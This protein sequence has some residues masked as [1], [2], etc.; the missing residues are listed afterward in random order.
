MKKTTV[1][2]F[3]A[4][5]LTL[6]AGGAPRAQVTL[7]QD[8]DAGALDVAASVVDL[9]NPLQPAITLE[10]RRFSGAW[11]GDHW[12]VSFSVS[13]VAGTT[14]RFRLPTAGAFQTYTNEHRWVW[15]AT[16]S[17]ETSWSFFDLG[18]V[19][20]GGYFRSANL[21]PFTDDTV[22]V[23]YAIPY[24]MS[25]TALLAARLIGHPLVQATASGDAGLVIGVTPGTV[26]GGYTDELGRNVPPL[27]LYGFVIGEGSGG[28]KRKVV[29]IAGNHSGE[30]TGSWTLEGFVFFLLG[31]DPAAVELRRLADV[32]V[33]PQ[34]DPEG[35]YCGYFRS[36]PENPTLNHNRSWEAPAGFTDI[37]LVT[38]AMTADTGG[39]V[40]VF[41]DFHGFGSATDIGYLVPTSNAR[42]NVLLGAL[43]ALEPSLMDFTLP[44]PQPGATA[45]R[46]AAAPQGLSAEVTITSEA[47]S[48]AGEGVDRYLQLGEGYARAVLAALEADLPVRP[49]GSGRVF[50]QRALRR[51]PALL[52]G[53][54]EGGGSVALDASGNGRHGTYVGAVAWSAES[55]FVQAG[56]R[57]LKLDGT[58]GSP[59][60]E[61][62]RVPDFGY[63]GPGGAFTLAFWFRTLD[64]AGSGD[65]SLFGHGPLAQAGSLNVY[66][67]ETPAVGTGD[68]LRTVVLDG[69]DPAGYANVLDVSLA[70]ADGGWHLY[71][72]VGE[73]G[74][75]A[76]LYLD[77]HQVRRRD[78]I[79]GGA[80]DPVGDLFLG[81]RADLDPEAFYG[82]SAA[83]DGGLDELLLFDRALDAGEVLAL[84]RSPLRLAGLQGGFVTVSASEGGAW[85]AVR[86]QDGTPVDALVAAEAQGMHGEGPVLFVPAGG[87]FAPL[88]PALAEH[89]EW[90][91]VWQRRG[92]G[93]R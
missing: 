44:N 23:A 41:V 39:V 88:P 55:A 5:L 35:R 21:A 78:Q 53:L 10:P 80:F 32:Y 19:D 72:L 69:D 79:L 3:L 45:A 89:L 63:A 50:R 57:S 29:A 24:P 56:G 68:R 25:R 22:Y 1:S 83:Q 62:V 40:D 54:D 42:T 38:A 93:P 20:A 34:V 61:Y 46:W 76:T 90:R 31:D 51:A 8:F 27:P 43:G 17:V 36:N 71:T 11:P 59:G 73:A 47:G 13:G 2:A 60:G 77:G 33:Y 49:P 86:D 9:T 52:L 65:Q 15:S 16:P 58:S 82:T 14:P 85:L 30:P 64:L 87:L 28:P 37:T 81:A 70:P 26:G 18:F 75:G 48:L 67:E 66:F 74:G 92:G 6:P 91:V 4:L 12:W 7:F 84:A